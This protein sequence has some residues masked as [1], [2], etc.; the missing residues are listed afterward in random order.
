MKC[1][2]ELFEGPSYVQI[3]GQGTKR[4]D[5]SQSLLI[6]HEYC[7]VNILEDMTLLKIKQ[8]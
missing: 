6:K 8:L 1:I 7:T 5:M 3:G 2:T 4:K